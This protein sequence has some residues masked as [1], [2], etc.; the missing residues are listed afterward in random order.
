[1]PDHYRPSKDAM[2]P[3]RSPARSDFPLSHVLHK[4]DFHDL[5]VRRVQHEPAL[6]IQSPMSPHTF[7]DEAPDVAVQLERAVEAAV[8]AA[9]LAF[10]RD[11]ASDEM[12]SAKKFRPGVNVM[13]HK[14]IVENLI[15]NFGVF[16]KMHLIIPKKS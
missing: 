12:R 2:G 15:K 9:P 6:T 11:Q 4:K 1:M 3:P 5:H 16:F 10:V 8:E 13:I 14:K 7:P